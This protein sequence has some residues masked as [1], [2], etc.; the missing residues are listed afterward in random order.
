MDFRKATDIL[1][2]APTHADIADAAGVSTQ[3]VRQARMDPASKSYRSPPDGWEKAL[4]K[5]ARDRAA[6]LEALAE[7]LEK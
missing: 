5:L 6:Q 3:S 2:S 7:D 1:T 4:G